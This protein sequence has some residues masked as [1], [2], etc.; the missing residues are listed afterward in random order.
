MPEQ[1][2]HLSAGLW[3]G[4]LMW[5][6]VKRLQA[7]LSAKPMGSGDGPI[8]VLLSC[9]LGLEHT[10]LFLFLCGFFGMISFLVMPRAPSQNGNEHPF[11]PAIALAFCSVLFYTITMH[12]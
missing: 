10:P 11:V 3:S 4:C 6:G 7:R 1:L 5:M 12:P 8:I 9:Y 2:N